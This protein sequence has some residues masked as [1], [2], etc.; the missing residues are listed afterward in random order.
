MYICIILDI[1]QNQC[2]LSISYETQLV[3]MIRVWE[4]KD[5]RMLFILPSFS[6]FKLYFYQILLLKS[7]IF[8]YKS[9]RKIKT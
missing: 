7:K 5:R 1:K 3:L 2:V 8:I 4:L 6:M 9:Y